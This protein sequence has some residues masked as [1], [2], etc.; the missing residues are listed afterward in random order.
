MNLFQD[1]TQNYKMTP[2]LKDLKYNKMES[3]FSVTFFQIFDL[4]HSQK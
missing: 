2:K 1:H 3:H 4:M